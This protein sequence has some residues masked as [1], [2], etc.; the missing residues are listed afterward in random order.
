M[1]G[2]WI[3]Q[4]AMSFGWCPNGL[5]VYFSSE[6]NAESSC[7]RLA[8]KSLDGF[9]GEDRLNGV[10]ENGIVATLKENCV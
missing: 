4:G 10:N 2:Y 6:R 1:G 5:S 8:G 7:L 3:M 9:V